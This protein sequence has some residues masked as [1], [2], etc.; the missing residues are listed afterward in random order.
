MHPEG[1]REDVA[2]W[3]N[4]EGRLWVI[5]VR[6]I[7][8]WKKNISDDLSKQRLE[9]RAWIVCA[10]WWRN[11][12]QAQEKRARSKTKMGGKPISTDH[13]SRQEIVQQWAK[14]E[15][16]NWVRIQISNT[17]NWRLSFD[18]KQ[19]IF[20]I[21]SWRMAERFSAIRLPEKDVLERISSLAITRYEIFSSC[22]ILVA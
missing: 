1:K 3:I 12:R 4:Y 19:Q 13:S 11:K 5:Q 6:E 15:E 2:R 18:Q 10:Y 21:A 16:W 7:A 17:K 20:K 22:S 14:R 9:Y 8:N